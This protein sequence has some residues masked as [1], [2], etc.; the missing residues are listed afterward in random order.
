MKDVI[1]EVEAWSARGAKVAIAT[2]V[3]V[4]KSAPRPTG[5]KMAV[6]SA[7]D[8][9]G[10]VSG[11]CVEGSV[12]EAADGILD[13]GPPQLLRFGIADEEA[14]SVGLPCGGEIDVFV[15]GAAHPGFA[16][17]AR[18]DGRGALVTV[19]RGEA[20]GA[21]LLVLADGATDGTLGDGVLDAAAVAAAEELMWEER[22]ELRE[23][24]ETAFFVDVTAPSPRLICFGAVDFSVA[25]C[26]VARAVGWRPFVVDPRG[27]FA[28]LERFPD[29]EQVVAAW[30]EAAFAQLGGL[31]R[32]TAVAVLTHDPKLDD[33]ALLLA[34][35]SDAGYI[36][37]M[38]SR[39]ANEARRERLLARGV[40]QEQLERIAAPIGLDLGAL[41]VE[42]TALSVMAEI[43]ALRHGRAGG[44]LKDAAGRIHEVEA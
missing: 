3:G 31:D 7:G 22:S 25:L 33:A 34:L 23:L 5:S 29:A 19:V 4:R 13:G 2:V 41:T 20:L 15:E 38:G 32:A 42:E 40:T 1:E 11:G 44:R 12:V 27:R 39:T 28:T 37:A 9:A 30:P 24:D 18:A 6:S 16:A 43:V 10:A 21:K 36:G 35:E 14:W 8:I 26:R 17:L